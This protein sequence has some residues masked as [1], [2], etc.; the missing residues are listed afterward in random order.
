MEGQIQNLT[1]GTIIF[2]LVILGFL[3]I[4]YAASDKDSSLDRDEIN[5]FNNT[6][7]KYEGLSTSTQ[8]IRGTIQNSTATQT[9]GEFGA[10]NSIV[11]SSWGSIRNSFTTLGFMM[12]ILSD[13]S[14]FFGVFAIPNWLTGLL[15]MML[16]VIIGFSIWALA[17]Q[18]KP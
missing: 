8:R 2:V 5:R 16:V 6:Y 9:E 4:M 12:D 3:S 18:R 7:N 13:T 14:I 11:I 17:F 10:I 1:L 15:V